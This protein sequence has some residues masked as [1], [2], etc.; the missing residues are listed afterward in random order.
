MQAIDTNVIVR[1]LT[2][3]EHAQ[4]AR[5]KTLFAENEVFVATTVLLETEWVLRG[6]YSQPKAE[7]IA[8]LRAF[9]GLATVKL[10]D[11]ARVEMALT[12]AA[13]GMDFADA[14]HLSSAEGCEAL[15]TFDRRF[16]KSASAKST[17]VVREP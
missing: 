6:A 13:G 12:L 3:D 17:I 11:P 1:L 14:L 4:S 10:E 16:V 15:V 5:A 7:V 9:A 2:N 8:A